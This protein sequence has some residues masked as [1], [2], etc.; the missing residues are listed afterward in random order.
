[1]NNYKTNMTEE[2]QVSLMVEKAVTSFFE[3]EE[4]AEECQR[5]GKHEESV[6]VIEAVLREQQEVVHMIQDQTLSKVFERLTLAYNHLGM[7][8]LKAEQYKKAY[9]YLEKSIALTDKANQHMENTARLFL[10][11]KSCS[12]MG[13]YYKARGKNHSALTMMKTCYE[14]EQLINNKQNNV[15]TL[16]NLCALYSQNN[17]HKM[18]LDYAQQAIKI[19]QMKTGDILETE[20]LSGEVDGAE[21]AEGDN[22]VPDGDADASIV[23]VAYFNLGAEFEHL[24]ELKA[25]HESY[26]VAQTNAVAHLG[27]EH[28]LTVQ[29]RDAVK[30]VGARIAKTKAGQKGK[31]QQPKDCQPKGKEVD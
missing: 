15:S 28:P 16:L 10:R 14:I 27:K 26:T 20:L 18:A 1:M 4:I 31:K 29:I 19:L 9:N 25:A 21:A 2:S 17:K 6:R 5:N 8:D 23:C 13:C 7:D 12:N 24:G 30:A 11:A 22:N 3:A